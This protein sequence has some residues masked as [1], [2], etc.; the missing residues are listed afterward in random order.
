M[1]IALVS[2]Y[3]FPYP[4][5]VTEHI[6]ALA[7]GI[8]QQGHEV[9]ILAACSGYQGEVFPNTRVVTHKVAAI[10]IGGAVARVGLSP[11]SYIRIKK[12]LRQELFDVIHLQEPLT[13]SITW[14]VLMQARALPGTVTIGTF[15]AYHEQPNWLYKRGRPVFGRFF[16]KLN[17]LI[18]VS[19]AARHFAYQ[20]FPGDYRIIPNGVDLNRFGKTNQ[21]ALPFKP[22]P[23]KKLTVLFVGRL[24]KRKGFSNLLDAFIKIKPN[25][26]QLQLQVIGPF[27]PKDCQPYQKIAQAHSVTDIEFVGYVSSEQLPG[28]YHNADIFCAPSLGY[29]SFGIVLL[30]AMAAGLPVVASDI[31]GYRAVIADG[32]EGLLAPPGQ[33]KALARALRQLL[34]QPCQR[35]EMGQRGRL[36]A[37]QYSWDCIVDKTL[38]V[39]TDTIERKIK[40]PINFFYRQSKNNSNGRTQRRHANYVQRSRTQV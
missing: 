37:S 22:D 24:D 38:E 33:P 39:Y 15:H 36:K 25:Y 5:G 7:N 31:A 10:P 27:E 18:A 2:P 30:E 34:D 4:G 40:M 3:D 14:W 12:I 29:E 19:E 35:L 16:T 17:S 28:F 21:K 13:P 26:P 6:I 20:M 9:H 1:K 32:Q 23:N 11:L 8:R